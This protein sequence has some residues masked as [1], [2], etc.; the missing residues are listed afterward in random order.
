MYVLIYCDDPLAGSTVIYGSPQHET[1]HS[2]H[3][4]IS[5]PIW[6]SR[7]FALIRQCLAGSS[8]IYYEYHLCHHQIL[9]CTSI[10]FLTSSGRRWLWS[11]KQVFYGKIP[12]ELP[13][14]FCHTP[15]T[16]SCLLDVFWSQTRAPC[17]QGL[18]RVWCFL[19]AESG[20]LLPIIA[21]EVVNGA[22]FSRHMAP[23]NQLTDWWMRRKYP[24][25]QAFPRLWFPQLH[26]LP[27]ESHGRWNESLQ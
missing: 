8:L 16:C 1:V 6:F 18:K 15:S 10:N 2:F 23:H 26:P 5:K 3:T 27:F 12:T 20:I 17:P 14:P 11:V 21:Y 22:M 4:D 19:R 9:S 7:L 13:K 24:C 25:R